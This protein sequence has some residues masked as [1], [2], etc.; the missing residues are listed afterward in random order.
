M[1]ISL[2]LTYGLI[3]YVM[4]LHVG[5]EEWVVPENIRTP[6]MGGIEILPPPLMHS[7]IPKCSIPPPTQSEFQTPLPPSLSEFQRCFRPLQNFLFN[8]LTHPEIFFSASSK[9][10]MYIKPYFLRIS[11]SIN[12]SNMQCQL[13]NF[14][15]AT[16]LLMVSLNRYKMFFFRPSVH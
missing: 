15:R 10:T 9:N 14:P 2:N 3:A 8:L 1:A 4:I 11:Q 16:F 6:T 12:S 7:E 13:F 5:L